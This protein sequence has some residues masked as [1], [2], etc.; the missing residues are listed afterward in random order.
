MHERRKEKRF[1]S[2]SAEI[3]NAG[4]F[5]RDWYVSKYRDVLISGI[6]P[7]MHFVRIGMK[8]G[9]DPGPDFSTEY[10]ISQVPPAELKDVYPV[11]HFL[12]VGKKRGI[13]PQTPHETNVKSSA[14]GVEN[15]A[16]GESEHGDQKRSRRDL[17]FPAD[18][19]EINPSPSGSRADFSSMNICVQL[20]LY[21]LDMMDEFIA[22]LNNIPARFDLYVSLT[23]GEALEE[24]SDKIASKVQNANVKVRVFPNKGRDIAPLF[25]GFRDEIMGHD[26]VCHIHTKNSP[27]NSAKKDWRGQLLHNLMG[28]SG[29]AT[30][31][32]RIL[33]E[34]PHIGMI[35]PDYHPSLRD[36]ITWGT[37]FEKSKILASQLHLEINAEKL[38]PFP[39][40]SMFWAR[41]NALKPLFDL[42]LTF[43]SF[44][45]EAQQIDGTIA[46]AIERL[47]G[48]VV[49]SQGYELLQVSCTDNR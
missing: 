17:R 38:V 7:L 44:P 32:L 1:P 40:G 18:A 33:S 8:I 12:R 27:H 36:Q 24:V 26:I 9:R 21:Y 34:N 37:N 48:E 28:H 10:Y 22:Y 16:D 6:S 2:I 5:D 41:K 47:M 14:S 11:L 46:H 15:A 3:E 19:L 29:A 49:V 35:F 20:H 23:N 30:S 43:D 45:D 25:A 4:I 39:A 31:N 13:L 42:A